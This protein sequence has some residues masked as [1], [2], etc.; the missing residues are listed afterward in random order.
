MSEYKM[1]FIHIVIEGYSEKSY[2]LQLNRIFR[3]FDV[4][5]RFKTYNSK[6][7]APKNVKR[8]YKNACKTRDNKHNENVWI[9]LD[10]DCFKRNNLQLTSFSFALDRVYFFIY[11]FEDFLMQHQT[12]NDFTK[13][14]CLCCRDRHIYTPL[15]GDAIIKNIQ[16]LIPNYSKGTMPFDLTIEHIKN[17]K[18]NEDRGGFIKAPLPENINNFILKLLPNFE[19][20]E[21]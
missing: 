18:N 13:W 7:N 2:F 16:Q 6:G 5:I 4:D 3:D 11:N 15:H 12:P 1:I 14:V 17:L 10:Y 19:Q 20:I 21:L 9:L 8:E